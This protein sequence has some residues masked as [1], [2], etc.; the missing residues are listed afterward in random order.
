MAKKKVIKKRVT[1]KRVTKKKIGKKQARV[2]KK[3]VVKK[4]VTKKKVIRKRV[5]KKKVANTRKAGTKKRVA[6]KD[7]PLHFIKIVKG[8]NTYYFDGIVGDTSKSKAAQFASKTQANKIAQT[9]ADKLGSKS[10]VY[11]ESSKKK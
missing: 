9:L 3:R 2:V 7:T 11:V 10:K 6:K 8:N 5:V 4:K 1:K